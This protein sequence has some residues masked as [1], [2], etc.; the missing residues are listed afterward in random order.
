MLTALAPADIDFAAVMPHAVPTAV[1]SSRSPSGP[2]LYDPAEFTPKAPVVDDLAPDCKYELQVDPMGVLKECPHFY[3]A[4]KTGGFDHSQGLW[5]QTVL[6]TTWFPNGRAFA[7][8]LSNKYPTYSQTEANAMYD[9]KENDRKSMGLGWPSCKTFENYG[10]KRCAACKHH[11]KIRSP[12]NLRTG[13]TGVT[14]PT[15]P[16]GV[17]GPTGSA[18]IA[19]TPFVDP[20]AEFVGPPFPLDVLSPTLAKF[21]DAEHRALGAD[22]SAIAMA[23]LTTVAGAMHAETRIRVRESWWEK[24]ILWTALVGQ[25]STK[26]SPI[27]EKTKKPLSGIDHERDKRWRQENAIWQQ[28]HQN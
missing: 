6:A 27:I 3:E 15:G 2:K 16:T 1:A 11:G 5:M 22:P 13:P 9:R 14:G 4:W 10:C 8:K 28:N 19:G 23:A 21:V 24:P 17:T 7:H 20:Y 26:K 18:P 25:P 12:L